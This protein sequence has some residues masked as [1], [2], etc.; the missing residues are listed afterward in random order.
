MIRDSEKDWSSLAK[1]CSFTPAQLKDLYN[2]PFSRT[3]LTEA[4][5]ILKRQKN[6]RASLLKTQSLQRE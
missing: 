5:R 6:A 2:N 4:E 3:L 1:E